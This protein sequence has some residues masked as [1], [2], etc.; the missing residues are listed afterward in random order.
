MIVRTSGNGP[1]W[2]QSLNKICGLMKHN[3]S[4]ERC[5]FNQMKPIFTTYFLLIPQGRAS[6]FHTLISLLNSCNDLQFL[7]F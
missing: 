2:K 4:Y 3:K 1:G 6:G 5:M 7:I